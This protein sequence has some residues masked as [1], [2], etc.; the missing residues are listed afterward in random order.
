MMARGRFNSIT[1]VVCRRKGKE[2]QS[3]AVVTLSAPAS[4][5][6]DVDEEANQDQDEPKDFTLPFNAGL[7][8]PVGRH[9]PS[10]DS[11]DE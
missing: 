7:W 3:G 2:E 1:C 8:S 10:P 6:G 5:C 11:S 9:L 4:A